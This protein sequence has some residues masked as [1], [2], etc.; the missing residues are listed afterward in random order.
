MNIAP[1]Q[2]SEILRRHFAWCREEE[3]GERANLSGA[4]LS[5]ANLRGADLSGANLSGADLR[6][7]NLSGADLSGADLSEA[8]KLAGVLQIGPIGSR[9]D[10]LVIWLLQDGSRRYSTGCQKQITEE[11]LLERNENRPSGSAHGAD[12]IAAVEFARAWSARNTHIAEV[13]K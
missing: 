5:G 1:E 7:A 6:G 8:G 10:A 3:G 2:L 12:Y 9:G 13:S 11:T 4:D